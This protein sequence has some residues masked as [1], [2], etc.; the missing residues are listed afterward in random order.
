MGSEIMIKDLIKKGD[1]KP[2]M[3]ELVFGVTTGK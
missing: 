2:L 1:V 3:N